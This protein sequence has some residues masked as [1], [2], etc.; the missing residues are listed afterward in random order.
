MCLCIF[1]G[2]VFICLYV[3][4][5]I[6]VLWNGVGISIVV[7]VYRNTSLFSFCTFCISVV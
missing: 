3:A 1:L 5:C 6:V 7:G 2:Y 4:F